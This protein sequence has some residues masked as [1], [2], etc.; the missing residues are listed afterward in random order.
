MYINIFVHTSRI[1]LLRSICGVGGPSDRAKV[2]SIDRAIDRAIDAHRRLPA[3]VLVEYREATQMYMY[4]A[5]PSAAGPLKP[6]WSVARW[7]SG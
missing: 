1:Q 4:G 7:L 5:S 2:R 3:Y 6:K